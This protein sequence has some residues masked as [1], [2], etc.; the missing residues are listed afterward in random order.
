[1]AVETHNPKLLQGFLSFF[2]LTKCKS[3]KPVLYTYRSLGGFLVHLIPL[4]T[5]LAQ[6]DPVHAWVIPIGYAFI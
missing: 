6:S 5:F 3:E 4:Q 2:S 1:M